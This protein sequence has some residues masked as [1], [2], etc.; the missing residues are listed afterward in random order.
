MA[1][2]ASA[3]SAIPNASNGGFIVDSEYK[4]E[5]DPPPI[6]DAPTAPVDRTLRPLTIKQVV[7]AKLPSDDRILDVIDGK[8]LFDVII[9]GRVKAINSR[10]ANTVIMLSDQT[11]RIPVKFW[12]D[13]NPEVK[14]KLSAL[15]TNTIIRAIGKINCFNGSFEVS[16]FDFW[17][18]TPM[19]YMH[20]M[21]QCIEAHVTNTATPQESQRIL[22]HNIQQRQQYQREY[23]QRIMSAQSRNT[24]FNNA[25]PMNRNYGGINQQ[26]FN[27]NSSINGHSNNN[28]HYGGSSNGNYNG[29]L[30]GNHN[31]NHN[32][33]YNRMQQQQPRGGQQSMMRGNQQQNVQNRRNGVNANG[34]KRNSNSFQ[35]GSMVHHHIKNNNGY[36]LKS[37]IAAV[38]RSRSGGMNKACT[39]QQIF[40]AL[41]KEN[42]NQVMAKLNEMEREGTI[43]TTFDDEGYMI[44]N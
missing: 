40:N 36:G 37:R 14:A 27:G 42:I 2:R 30:N 13:N 28:G 15:K 19:E 22:T 21:L 9:M 10:T 18:S 39:K 4:S 44:A 43:F 5:P 12:S 38:I 34:M 32:G 31:G 11:G 33:N 23:N 25:A 3:Y 29:N 41:S 35:S 24:N 1:H 6:S 16:A 26:Q 8:P 17:P 20:F 7:T